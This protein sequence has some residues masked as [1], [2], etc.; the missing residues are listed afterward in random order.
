[1][2]A[3]KA[4]EVTASQPA[5]PF[6]EIDLYAVLMRR[7]HL[8][9][10]VTIG[11]LVIVALY[12]IL[13]PPT[14]EATCRLLIQPTQSSVSRTEWD[15]LG[16]VAT[17]SIGTQVELARSQSV[18]EEA[19]KRLGNGTEWQHLRSML[20]VQP[21]KETDIL[22]LT[23]RHGDPEFAAQAANQ[24]AEAHLIRILEAVRSGAKAGREYVEE[25]LAQAAENVARSRAALAE[26]RA[27]TGQVSLENP[28]SE[29]LAQHLADL[30]N[31]VINAN[32]ELAA[33]EAEAQRLETELSALG[34]SSRKLSLAK[35]NSPLLVNL[36]GELQKAEIEKAE[37]L[38]E[39]TPNAPEVQA[40][41]KRI[42]AI[43]EQITE[44]LEQVVSGEVASDDPEAEQIR[45]KLVASQVQ[46]EAARARILACRSALAA[47]RRRL[48]ALPAQEAKMATLMQGLRQA[49]TLFN[50]L[51]ENYERYRLVEATNIS[52][53]SIIDRAQVPTI[54]VWPKVKLNIVVGL[55]L[56]LL[57]GV[58]LAVLAEQLDVRLR[59]FEEIRAI[60]GAPLLG[61]Y[62]LVRGKPPLIQEAKTLSNEID[63]W[64]NIKAN[65][66]FV[67]GDKVPRSLVVTSCFPDEGKT[68]AAINLAITYAREAMSVVLVDADLRRPSLHTRFELARGPGLADVM[69]STISLQDALHDTKIENLRL[70]T[71][72]KPL[73]NPQAA[74]ASTQMRTVISELQGMA[75]MIIFDAPPILGFMD[76]VLLGS[77]LDGAVLVVDEK[78][79]TRKALVEAIETLER[80]HLTLF[81][82][83]ANRHRPRGLRD[84][85]HP[86][87]YARYRYYYHA[88]G[89]EEVAA[90]HNES[91]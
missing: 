15:P 58:G 51:S 68:T 21:L 18:L 24:I 66:L 46:A 80:A 75:D 79:A 3:E 54:P 52:G 67:A 69:V 22:V 85:Y 70:L 20:I 27:R 23:V 72:G 4:K 45:Q 88:E 12:S 19:A 32:A 59:S 25:Q 1:M 55:L 64:R 11:L 78:I 48:E 28:G 16:L 30:E 6:V 49:E 5:N 50:Q 87:Y 38:E 17:R 91:T 35:G 43:R 84:Y 29:R 26:F 86:Y 81:G 34:H 77:N 74:M 2:D 90:E 76:A 33:A 47:G 44:A 83:I 8:I 31:T 73:F 82:T 13:I 39:Y 14:Y 61:V 62:P 41:E 42:S 36:R 37:L 65:I 63:A 56:G 10:I 7:W 71:C 53:A 60:T 57:L 89:A 40:V 9:A